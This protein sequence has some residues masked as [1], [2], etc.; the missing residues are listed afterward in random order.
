[1]SADLRRRTAAVLCLAALALTS[2]ACEKSG[3]APGGG[4]KPPSQS[5]ASLFD[6]RSVTVAVKKGQ[7]GFNTRSGEEYEYAGFETDL[8][9]SLADTIPFKDYQHDIP[10]L[11][12]EDILLDEGVDLVI[13]TYTITDARD[14]KIDFT[15]PYLKTYQGVLVRKDESEIKQLRDLEERRVCSASGSTSDPDSVEG[16]KAKK[17]ISETLGVGV[18]PGLRKDYKT[19]VKELVKGNFDAVWT[20]KIVLEGFAHA[21]PYK[22]DVEVV[23]DINVEKRQFYGVGLREGHGADCRK[24]NTALKK[25]LDTRW[26]TAFQQHFPE[27]AKGDF[28][29]KYKPSDSEFAD[30]EAKSCGAK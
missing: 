21:D 27:L 16:E 1:M 12:R 20:D 26:V 7:P 18:R 14:E 4:S 3:P 6:Q 8:L 24:L 29:Q 10:S 5:A 9:N 23:Q 28:E 2:A 19:C 30:Y 13:A 17:S 22:K 11:Q 15:A 25:F